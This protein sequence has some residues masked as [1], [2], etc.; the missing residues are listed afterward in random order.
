MTNAAGQKSEVSE[1][2]ITK[3]FNNADMDS[4][5]FVSRQ[6]AKR[7]YKRLSKLF[8]RPIDSVS[9]S[10]PIENR[11]WLCRQGLPR[12]A[13]GNNKLFWRRF[14]YLMKLPDSFLDQ[15]GTV[16]EVLNLRRSII[17][18]LP[19]SCPAPCNSRMD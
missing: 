10:S 6:E 11:F 17:S 2:E 14:H 7:A 1:A 9:I 15:P 12:S 16:L 4:D 13:W 5:G 19:R 18:L 8:S 3:A